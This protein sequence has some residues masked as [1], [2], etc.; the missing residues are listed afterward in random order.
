MGL[1]IPDLQRPVLQNRGYALAIRYERAELAAHLLASL[2]GEQDSNV[3]AAW[4][5]EIEP[6]ARETL[7]KPRRRYRLG[8]RA[9]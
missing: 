8:V 3:E 6:R 1:E 5:S 4:A 7:A 2:D 9:R